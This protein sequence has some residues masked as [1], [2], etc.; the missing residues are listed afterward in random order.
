MLLIDTLLKSCGA[1]IPHALSFIGLVEEV[2]EPSLE[3]GLTLGN[4][5]LGSMF[6]AMSCSC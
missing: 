1:S 3:H 4:G 6:L 2:S 5:L